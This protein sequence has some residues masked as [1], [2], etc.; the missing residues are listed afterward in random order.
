MMIKPEADEDSK[1]YMLEGKEEIKKWITEELKR[2]E[3]DE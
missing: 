1:N 2:V 3:E